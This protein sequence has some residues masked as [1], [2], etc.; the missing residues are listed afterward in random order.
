[1]FTD[2]IPLVQSMIDMLIDTE[3]EIKREVFE[4]TTVSF[5]KV[6]F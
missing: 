6:C 2:S 3:S 5:L 4:N 1:M